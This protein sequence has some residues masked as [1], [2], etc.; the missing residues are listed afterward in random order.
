MLL[1]HLEYCH[2]DEY[3]LTTLWKKVSKQTKQNS[4]ILPFISVLQPFVD[5]ETFSRYDKISFYLLSTF[6]NFISPRRK[7][8]SN[9]CKKEYNLN[10]NLM[11][12]TVS[13]FLSKLLWWLCEHWKTKDS[14]LKKN[15]ISPLKKGKEARNFLTLYCISV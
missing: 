4:T 14:T 9:L 5:G 2:L 15:F 8:L 6:T 10:E 7:T 13:A 12:K 11:N 1:T 3:F